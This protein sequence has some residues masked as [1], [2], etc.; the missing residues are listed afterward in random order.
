MQ[1][2]YSKL[3]SRLEPKTHVS[4]IV[5]TMD[6][7][8]HQAL[9]RKNLTIKQVREEIVSH[10]IRDTGGETDYVLI[11]SGKRLPLSQTLERIRGNTTILLQRA[12]HQIKASDQVY[13]LFADGARHV[14]DKLPAVIGRSKQANLVD[15]NLIDQPENLTVSRRHAELA[16]RDGDYYISNIT[17]NPT[18]RP[19]YLNEDQDSNSIVDST[20]PKLIA[21][22]YTIRMGKVSFTFHVD[23][24]APTL[25]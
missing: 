11:M 20:A 13:L 15:I 19:I 16:Y 9:F 22:G 4:L 24:T 25:D 23:R 8:H 10:L 12:D 17:D 3:R 7:E 21:D 1:D 5:E 18:D 14:I 6:G 2:R